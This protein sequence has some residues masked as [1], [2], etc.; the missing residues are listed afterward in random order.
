[1]ASLNVASITQSVD[2][3]AKSTADRGLDLDIPT[4]LV[5]ITVSPGLLL[6]L[7]V[8]LRSLDV[9][10]MGAGRATTLFNGAAGIGG[11]FTLY[12]AAE[13]LDDLD[14]DVHIAELL[15]VILVTALSGVI[16]AYTLMPPNPISDALSDIGAL[17]E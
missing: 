5:I 3:Y 11:F 12:I 14:R 1:M 15:P 9:S 7:P 8:L 2:N 13:F 6:L 16:A 10:G 4:W 17:P